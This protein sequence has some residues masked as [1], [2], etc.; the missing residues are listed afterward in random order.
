MSRLYKTVQGDMW[1]SIAYSQL[2]D[3][4]HTDKLMNAN[5]QYRNYYIF[6]AGVVLT[7]PD[8]KPAVNDVLP[9][10]KRGSV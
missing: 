4:A 5:Q 3:C 7:L 8:V 2:G 1:D 6:P 9:P 10:W